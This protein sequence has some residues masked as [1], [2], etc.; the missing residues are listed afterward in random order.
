MIDF[1]YPIKTNPAPEFILPFL[2]TF[3]NSQSNMVYGKLMLPNVRFLQQSSG[4]KDFFWIFLPIRNF[5]KMLYCW[6]DMIFV[7]NMTCGS[8]NVLK[9]QSSKANR[10]FEVVSFFNQYP[11]FYFSL[12]HKPHSI[13]FNDWLRIKFFR[14]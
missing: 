2:F 12:N 3:Q 4:Q 13:D 6:Q 9:I 5:S 11:L 7:C 10:V 1:F 14:A 8:K